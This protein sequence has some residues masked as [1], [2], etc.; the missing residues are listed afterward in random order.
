MHEQRRLFSVSSNGSIEERLERIDFHALFLS[1]II[2][3][4]HSKSSD[5]LEISSWKK[6]I[7]RLEFLPE[8]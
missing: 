7:G 4:V 6:C 3:K 2:L 8:I 1:I 5:Y